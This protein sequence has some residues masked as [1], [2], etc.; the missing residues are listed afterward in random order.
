MKS[1]QQ[2]SLRRIFSIIHKS[3]FSRMLPLVQ[4]VTLANSPV[5]KMMA[6]YLWESY[7]PVLFVSYL[8]Y[9]IVR[10]MM[11]Y[12]SEQVELIGFGTMI[13]IF[14]E[15]VSLATYST[16][17]RNK[18]GYNFSS[19]HLLPVS[20]EEL[21]R[22]LYSFYL[23][24][25][26]LSVGIIGV[27]FAKHIH[28]YQLYV[29]LSVKFIIFL[30]F[31]G[32][33][34]NHWSRW[35]L[36]SVGMMLLGLTVSLAITPKL[37]YLQI[38][39]MLVFLFITNKAVVF[40]IY[41]NRSSGK[42]LNIKIPA[43]STSVDSKD[44]TV[45]LAAKWRR[46]PFSTSLFTKTKSRE[47]MV[48][49]I[50]MLQERCIVLGLFML[51]AMVCC[52]LWFFTHSIILIS[53][54]AI[55]GIMPLSWLWKAYRIQV[56]SMNY[57]RILSTYPVSCEEM[58]QKLFLICFPLNFLLGL[59]MAGSFVYFFPRLVPFEYSLYFVAKG[60]IFLLLITLFA[61]LKRYN[62][63]DNHR[64]IE[65]NSSK[66]KYDIFLG[67]ILIPFIVFLVFFNRCLPSWLIIVLMALLFFASYYQVLVKSSEVLILGKKYKV[68]GRMTCQLYGVAVLATM[69]TVLGFL[70]LFIP[71][72]LLSKIFNLPVNKI[73][74]FIIY[75]LLAF[76]FG[77][78]EGFQVFFSTI[79]I[80]LRRHQ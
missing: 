3:I 10:I 7:I 49:W 57:V 17:F 23:I 72:N 34:I 8:M 60:L 48:F 29:L 14:A 42:R 77:L 19:F 55:S 80:F 54:I 39:S 79:G 21:V 35:L 9:L 78:N 56:V 68:F 53:I 15:G 6:K 13:F 30:V 43:S 59:I 58:N 2:D 51:A 18:T 73:T 5:K 61:N 64:F 63:K 41:R 67:Y 28:Y 52:L 20:P 16:R 46:N 69:L 38:P 31:A 4:A 44:K 65:I 12:D 45:N 71:A 75:L 25:I 36:F 74:A 32:L 66:Y 37:I 40:S 1:N 26:F 47:S 27:I 62:E 22:Y 24:S 50:L 70:Y 11:F 33:L 76:L